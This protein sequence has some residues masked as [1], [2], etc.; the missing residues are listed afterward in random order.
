MAH[1][2]PQGRLSRR[3]QRFTNDYPEEHAG[4][5]EDAQEVVDHRPAR[6][7]WVVLEQAGEASCQ[8]AGGDA[9]L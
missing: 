6:L 7:L 9:Q 2:F 8:G 3:G 1:L 4:Q 5:H